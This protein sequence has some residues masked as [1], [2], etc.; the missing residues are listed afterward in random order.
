M[1]VA[2]VP[3]LVKALGREEFT[4]S[5]LVEVLA[6]QGYRRTGDRI[7][8][9]AAQGVV[10]RVSRDWYV[11]GPDWRRRLLHRRWLANQILL[12]SVLSL[13][14]ALGFH[15][16]IP[17][18]VE[19][20]TSVTPCRGREYDT[21]EGT[22][23][24]VRVP[25]G[26]FPPGRRVGTLGEERFL[27]VSPEKALADRVWTARLPASVDWEA[28]LAEDLRLD[29]GFWRAADTEELRR[30]AEAFGSRRLSS[31]ALFFDRWRGEERRGR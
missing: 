30:F 16:L 1:G 27:V 29:E 10:R 31:L 11:L 8:T 24:Y 23:L 6:Q 2:S 26:A 12:P 19:V 18:G 3:G 20:L 4:R 25:E 22:F 17:E 13:E 9:L 5:R 21:P 7:A 28:Y 14:W 15:G